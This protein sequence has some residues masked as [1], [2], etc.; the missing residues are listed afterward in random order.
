M[1]S[2]TSLV[3]L[4]NR[5]VWVQAVGRSLCQVGYGLMQFY[6]PIVFVNQVGLSATA[7]GFSISSSSLT[8]VMGHFLGGILADNP[9]FGR[10]KTLLF[11][12]GLAILA[13][14][15]LVFTQTIPLL[16]FDNLLLGLSI[17]FYWTAADAAVMDITTTEERHRAFAILGLAEH[18]GVGVGVL[19]GGVLLLLFNRAQWLFA[20]CSAIFLIFV[21]MT[22][23]AIAETQPPVPEKHMDTSQGIWLALKDRS[24]QIFVLANVLFTTYIA[25]VTSTLPLY[26]TNFV[27]AF[28]MTPGSSLDETANLFTWCYIGFGSLLQ[29][30]IVYLFGTWPR[31]RVLMLAM[32]LWSGG[33]ILVWLTGNATSFQFLWAIAALCLLSLAAVTYKPFAAAIVA[34]LAPAARRGAYIA[35]SSQCWAIGYFIGPMLG[36]WAMDQTATI[37]HTFW[38]MVASST[39]IGFLVLQ[40]FQQRVNSLSAMSGQLHQPLAE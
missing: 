3:Q 17:G 14:I 15:S 24:L 7:V 8:S 10:R 16:I 21:V 1:N 29:L 6:I 5:Q 25:L 40:L 36:G 2:L 31:V 33:F 38:V 30:P 37:A 19:G 20:S 13:A 11:S 18:L 34:E 22:L 9:R 23:G 35:V 39:A 12:A 28:G 27:A 4:S 32:L 26:L